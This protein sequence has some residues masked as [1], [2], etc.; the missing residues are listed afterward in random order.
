[1]DCLNLHDVCFSKLLTPPYQTFAGPPPL[2]PT[3]DNKL[4]SMDSPWA[5]AG[6]EHNLLEY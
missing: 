1:M 2:L 4:A 5:S 6:K 3:Q